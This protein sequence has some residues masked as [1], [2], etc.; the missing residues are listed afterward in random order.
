METGRSG[1]DLETLS[2]SE[3]KGLEKSV[4]KAITNFGERHKAEARARGDELACKLGFFRIERAKAAPDC[5]CHG[6]SH[7]ARLCPKYLSG[8]TACGTRGG[9]PP[10]IIPMSS[11]PRPMAGR[12]LGRK[13]P[14][15]AMVKSRDVMREIVNRLY[16]FQLRLGEEEFRDDLDR[17]L[18][19]SRNW[20]EPRLDWNLAGS[21]LRGGESNA[22]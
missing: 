9:Q 11:R 22:S 12:S 20:D 1:I 18:T 4:A 13:Y 17:Q 8:D 2:L 14:G 3:L 21:R 6:Q 7:G 15:S 10:G 16:A 19:S 5:L